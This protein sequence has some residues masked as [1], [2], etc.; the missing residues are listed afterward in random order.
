MLDDTTGDAG[1]A[2]ARSPGGEA[3][4]PD[5]QAGSTPG[6]SPYSGHT[7]AVSTKVPCVLQ[8]SLPSVNMMP[9]LW[10]KPMA[11]QHF[12]LGTSANPALPATGSGVHMCALPGC[13]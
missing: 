9:S 6:P 3:L 2:D 11:E 5:M 1:E 8:M 12:A 13:R 7:H 10:C 4:M